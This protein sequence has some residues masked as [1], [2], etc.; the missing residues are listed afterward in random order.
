MVAAALLLAAPARLWADPPGRS[1]AFEVW[2]SGQRLGT[3]R[4]AFAGSDQDFVATIDA[5][6]ELKL[7][8]LTLFR[9]RHQAAETWRGGRFASLTSRTVSNG[10]VEQVVAQAGPGG[11]AITIGGGKRLMASAG[12]HPLT[13][14]NPAVLQGSLF[15]P[16]TGKPLR[17]SVVRSDGQSLALADGRRVSATRFTLA[18]DADIVDWYASGVWT[19]LRGRLWDGSYVEYRRAA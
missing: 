10:K 11:V 1:L 4:V 8:A 3:H 13:H 7:G 12:A 16:E 9:Y 15:N 2:R 14:W 18:G 17:E 5:Q 6:M 19:A